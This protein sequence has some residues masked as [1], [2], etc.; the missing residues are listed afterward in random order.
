MIL[1]PMNRQQG[2]T[3]KEHR[4][5]KF[6]VSILILLFLITSPMVAADE[7]D[8]SFVILDGLDVQSI[9]TIPEKRLLIAGSTGGNMESTALLRICDI[10]GNILWSHQE[11]EHIAGALDMYRDAH[12]IDESTSWG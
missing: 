4:W 8:K 9:A 1:I 12:Y 7:I 6:L 3:N 5:S 10:N 2:I 11:E